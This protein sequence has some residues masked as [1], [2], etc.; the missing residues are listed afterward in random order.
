MKWFKTS[1][2]ST[3]EH[4]KIPA[5][6][7]GNAYV[8][9][10]FLRSLGSE[11]I[12]MSPLSYAAVPFSISLDDHKIALKLTTPDL[13]KPGDKLKITYSASR[14]TKMIL[15]GVDEGILQ[16]A[17]YKL[18]DPLSYFF[19]R[20]ALQVATYQLLDL[21]LPEFSVVQ[22]LSAPG[23]D[24]GGRGSANNLNPFKR[25]T[26]K[27]VA[28]WSGVIDAGPEAKTYTYDV[29]DYFNGNIKVMA[30]ATNGPGFGS[31]EQN[32]LSRGDFIIS[33]NVP[34]AVVPGDEFE[35]GVGLSNQ[36]EG[37]GDKA[38][39]QLELISE[40]FEVV[41][42][43]LK[44][45]SIPEGHEGATSFHL[46]AKSALGSQAIRFK[47]SSGT[48]MARASIETS[49]RPALPFMTDINA[50]LVAKP[51]FDVPVTRQLL[52]EFMTQTAGISPVPLILGSGLRTFL[53]NYPY[54]CSEQ[55]TS[56]LFPFVLLKTR[57]EFKIDAKKAN[58]MFDAT[59]GTLRTRQTSDGGFAMY[60]AA[61]GSEIPV[62]LYVVHML[63]EAKEKGF[64]VPEDMYE[65]ALAYIESEA[66]HD[67]SS[68]HH[69]RDFAYSLY[70]RARAGH[71]PGGDLAFLHKALITNYKDTWTTDLTAAWLAAAYKLVKKDDEAKGIFKNLKPGVPTAA[72][73]ESFYDGFVRDAALL[74]LAARHFP[75]SLKEF[76]NE[77][78]MKATFSTLTRNQFNTHSAAFALLALDA[79]VST[80][81]KPEN[82]NGV[83]I[84]EVQAHDVLKSLPLPS[85][86]LLNE[87]SFS[88]LAEKVRYTVPSGFPY[89]FIQ[90]QAGFDRDLPKSVIQK[91]LELT[92]EYLDHDGKPIATAKM[93]DEIQV[94][95]RVRSL[96]ENSM[97]HIA[98]VDLLPSGLEAI[99][100]PVVEA[101]ASE[102]VYQGNLP[103]K[104]D[105]DSDDSSGVEDRQDSGD[106]SGNVPPPAPDDDEKPTNGD[107]AI[108]RL[109]QRILPEALADEAAQAVATQLQALD[110]QY[111]DHREDRVIVY[112]TVKKEV[113][114]YIYRAKAT[115]QG[116]FVVPPAFAESMY[117]REVQYRGL[118]STFK[119]EAP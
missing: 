82:Q 97:S 3:V 1:T 24:G 68:I 118:S 4:I 29:P 49:V 11:E 89:F 102:E 30:V 69:A 78:A 112:A 101:S 119:V 50:G 32:V 80:S 16:V 88:N 48:K 31:A 45:L 34:L 107:G 17:K 38:K 10:T 42:E 66:L 20:R 84:D 21:L 115:V 54:G 58:A 2:T 63:I 105:R 22:G 59:L 15:Y 46:R 76:T 35:V 113:T 61:H 70:L 79:M 114:E 40:G 39:V 43:P 99:L 71:V 44:S 117:D 41:G 8:N 64:R 98:I 60:A 14:K 5:G 23:G 103:E 28:F 96:S 116:T 47:A 67:T 7:E 72:N 19:Q 56:K 65:K 13:V 53:D 93:G 90:V 77:S 33:P 12:F 25:K 55:L 18:P 100:E 74:Y 26:D 111:V 91:G 6:L 106:D 94:R 83:K 73:Y 37:S 52:P 85:G 62:T 51:T 27:P 95:L 109:F 36:A 87:A 57:A 9:V 92:R 75:E 86:K 108:Y 104:E 81:Q 110:V